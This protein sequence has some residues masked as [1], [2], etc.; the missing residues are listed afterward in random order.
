MSAK[1]GEVQRSVPARL[2][3]GESGSPRSHCRKGERPLHKPRDAA[4]SCEPRTTR[5]LSEGSNQ[6]DTVLDGPQIAL[7]EVDVKGRCEQIQWRRVYEKA[8]TNLNS[9]EQ[10][11]EA[12]PVPGQGRVQRRLRRPRVPRS[13]S[14]QSD[15]DDRFRTAG[16]TCPLSQAIVTCAL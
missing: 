9:A 8:S 3:V 7:H 2:D 12:L 4:P 11:A 6:L 5:R 13:Q 10:L 16:A 1:A 15:R 14:P